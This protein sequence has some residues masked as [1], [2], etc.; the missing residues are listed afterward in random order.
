MPTIADYLKFA[1]LQVAAEALYNFNATPPGTNLTPSA[2]FAND[3]PEGIL[4]T[5]NLHN[6][7]FTVTEATKFAAQWTVVEHISN[8][9]TGFSGT[10][11][12]DKDTGDLVLSF[13]STEF[14]DDAARD[15]EATNKLE[16]SETGFA[17]GQLSDMESWYQ[18]LQATGKITGPLSVTGYSLGAHMATAFN[19]MHPGVA[20]QVINFN[21]A[22]IGTIGD[23][24]L[25]AT[26]ARLPA[27]IAR[28]S[29]LRSQGETT[30]FLD[31]FQSVEGRQAYLDIQAHL[32]STLGVPRAAVGGGFNDALTALA[33]AVRPNTPDDTY[34]A[35]READ[36]KLLN[37]AVSRIKQVYQAAHYAP[38]LGSGSTEGPPNPANVQDLY[39]R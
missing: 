11:F 35:Q 21:G 17:F 38:T 29:A 31:S 19:L 10:L 9:S 24:A 15:N 16:I 39:T 25:A 3:I 30:G 32:A 26:P 5:G 7:K 20:Q 6:S 18:S 36:Y 4:T 28:F 23:P 22:G 37:E 12:K 2:I 34:A 14:I 27:M 33:N 1:N 13:R 8:T